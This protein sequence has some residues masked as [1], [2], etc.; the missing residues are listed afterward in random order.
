MT[1]LIDG[2]MKAMMLERGIGPGRMASLLIDVEKGD[3]TAALSL[4]AALGARGTVHV[5]EG[6]FVAA[7]PLS[8]DTTWHGST[9][10]CPFMTLPDTVIAGLADAPLSRM[11]EVPA[12][13]DRRIASVETRPDP[14]MVRRNHHDPAFRDAF[15]DSLREPKTVSTVIHLHPDRR[16]LPDVIGR[17]TLR[18]LTGPVRRWTRWAHASLRSGHPPDIYDIGWG[19]LVGFGV[20]TVL[21]P[22]MVLWTLIW[23]SGPERA[24]HLLSLLTAMPLAAAVC[25]AW[26][27]VRSWSGCRHSIAKPVA[28]WYGRKQRAKRLEK[29]GK[30]R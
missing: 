29:T 7:V 22:L 27:T 24:D 17:Q 12:L 6:V 28:E 4:A 8:A 20:I 30:T 19:L 25:A 5:T 21:G 10:V 11:V 16:P 9:I 2:S 23:K 13:A 3:G 18:R 15:R 26:S 1:M 14:T